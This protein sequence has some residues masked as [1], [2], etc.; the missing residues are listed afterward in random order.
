MKD[1]I[2]KNIYKKNDPG[3]ANSPGVGCDFFYREVFFPLEVGLGLLCLSLASAGDLEVV[4][5]QFLNRGLNDVECG[6]FAISGP[7]LSSFD[8]FGDFHRLGEGTVLWFILILHGGGTEL[9]LELATETVREFPDLLHLPS[10]PNR[11]LGD[12]PLEF[13]SVRFRVIHVCD[14]DVG[15]VADTQIQHRSELEDEEAVLFLQN[16]FNLSAREIPVFKPEHFEVTFAADVKQVV[17]VEDNVPSIAFPIDIQAN[18]FAQ[19]PGGVLLAMEVAVEFG[20]TP[21]ASRNDGPAFEAE[22]LGD[23]DIPLLFI[24]GAG[25]TVVVAGIVHI[26]S[27]YLTVFVGILSN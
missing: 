13:T 19:V 14:V 21:A 6:G 17:E 20:P 23:E 1:L 10:D 11:F 26:R 15:V 4:D 22:I 7:L 18:E 3:Y 8:R 24:V 12:V 16:V 27:F 25:V 2:L 5:G 9:C